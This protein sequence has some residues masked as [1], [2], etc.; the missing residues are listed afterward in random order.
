VRFYLPVTNTD[1]QRSVTA[2]RAL[3]F[4]RNA[5]QSFFDWVLFAAD[6][7]GEGEVLWW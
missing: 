5:G 2:T 7:R 6:K 4:P 1:V 3:G